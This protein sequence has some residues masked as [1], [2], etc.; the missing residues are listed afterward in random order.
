MSDGGGG[1]EIAEAGAR[2]LGCDLAEW[3]AAAGGDLSAVVRLHLTTG[4][5]A[6]AKTGPD[7]EAEAG[8]L[9]AIRAAGVPA[10]GVLAVSDRVLVLEDLEDGGGLDENGWRDLG[11]ALRHLHG[12]V[13]AGYGWPTDYAFGRVVIRNAPC[14]TWP[15]FWAERR[16]LP[17]VA[18]LPPGLARRLE[19]LAADLPNRLPARPAPALLHGDLWAGNLL[20]AGGRL[21]G[22]IDP[23]C[24]HGHGEVDLAMLHLFGAPGAGLA[25]GYGPLP[26]GA[27]ER[28]AIYQLWPGIVHLR[29]FGGGYA[30]MLDRLLSRAGV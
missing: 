20:A 18:A 1:Q 29:L 16:L 30:G 19:R 17:E 5:T 9:E 22:L 14:D 8:M 27:K 3:R 15:A 21:S 11:V 24:Y 10:P 7:P 26:P 23:A 12:A 25:E 6:I 28:R 4:G 13:G 2:L